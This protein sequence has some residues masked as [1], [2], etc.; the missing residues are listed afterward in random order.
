VY[1]STCTRLP[2]PRSPASP[3]SVS[4]WSA[5]SAFCGATYSVRPPW[6]IARSNAG[7]VYARLFPLAV[8]VAT[9]TSSPSRTALTASAWCS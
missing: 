8:G 1:V 5:T 4:A 6:S 2:N 7:T 3:D 9:T